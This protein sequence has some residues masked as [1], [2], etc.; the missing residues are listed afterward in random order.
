MAGMNF[1]KFVV[2]E[3]ATVE[4]GRGLNMERRTEKRVRKYFLSLPACYAA[5]LSFPDPRQ[6]AATFAK[7]AR[8]AG[9]L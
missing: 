2:N 9:V 8:T 3:I 7:G 1:G 5:A 6:S 4:S